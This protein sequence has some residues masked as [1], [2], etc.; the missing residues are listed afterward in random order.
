MITLFWLFF[1]SAAFILK[2]QI[3]DPASPAAD[4][5]LEIVARDTISFVLSDGPSVN[6]S[7]VHHSLG[8][9]DRNAACA[10]VME[11][12]PVQY[13]GNCWLSLD[14]EWPQV[15]GNYAEPIGRSS[16][17]HR[18]VVVDEDVWTLSL[19]VW[20]LGGGVS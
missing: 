12:L 19:Q 1:M 20:A 8:M 11:A 2:I 18:L 13:D 10:T 6:Q 14:I 3:P 5:G 15:V 16:S 17:T 7:S 4:A 9:G